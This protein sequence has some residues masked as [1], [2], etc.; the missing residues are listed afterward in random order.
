MKENT[1]WSSQVQEYYVNKL[2]YLT[3]FE[4]NVKALNT[5]SV[6]DFAKKMLGQ[7]NVIEIIM[8]P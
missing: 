8:R 2:D 5:K 3:G 1:W 4:S 6:R 7:D